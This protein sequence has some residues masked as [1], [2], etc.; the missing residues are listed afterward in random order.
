[1]NSA[2]C[3]FSSRFTVAPDWVV[4]VRVSNCRSNW[5]SWS[6]AVL[7]SITARFVLP[8]SFGVLDEGVAPQP[9][10]T[11]AQPPIRTAA[12]RLRM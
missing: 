8:E 2:G 1:M 9:V 5:E 4:K 6:L 7:D 11:S 3:W 12:T 10:D